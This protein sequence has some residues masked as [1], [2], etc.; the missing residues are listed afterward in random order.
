[1]LFLLLYTTGRVGKKVFCCWP[2]SLH[3][4]LSFRVHALCV[5]ALARSDRNI[6]NF[7]LFLLNMAGGLFVPL[8]TFHFAAQKKLSPNSPSPLLCFG[9]ILH[10]GFA[11]AQRSK[12]RKKRPVWKRYV[13]L[14]ALLSSGGQMFWGGGGRG[15]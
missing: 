2:I 7:C 10:L 6:I 3:Y 5:R 13:A 11:K 1:M 9:Y 15:E 12:E 4:I 8:L 14:F